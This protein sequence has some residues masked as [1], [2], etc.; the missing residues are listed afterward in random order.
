MSARL[1]HSLSPVSAQVRVTKRD[2][3]ADNLCVAQRLDRL[4]VKALHMA[5]FAL[6][7]FGLFADIAEVALSHAFSGIFLAAPIM[8]L[9]Q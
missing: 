6:C 4:P 8:S 1:A 3:M 7:A 2:G 9:A 5:I